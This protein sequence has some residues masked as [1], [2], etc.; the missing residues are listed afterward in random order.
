MCVPQALCCGGDATLGYLN[1][2]WF[3]R[4]SGVETQSK[5]HRLVHPTTPELNC[6]EATKE[7]IAVRYDTSASSAQCGLPL[8]R[9]D[10]MHCEYS[11][12]SC[13]SGGGLSLFDLERHVSCLTIASW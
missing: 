11:Y 1:P 7:K 10:A 2:M 8:F 13:P 12:R 6:A 3:L 4:H 5:H 9:K